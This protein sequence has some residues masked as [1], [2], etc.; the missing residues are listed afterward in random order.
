M[1]NRLEPNARSIAA[2]VVERVARE[3]AFAAAVL[4]AA[5]ERF[6]ELDPRERALATELAYG[7]LRTAPYLEQ[8][9]AKHAAHGSREIE[10]TVRAHLV[11]AGYQLLFLE[12]VPAFAAVSEAVRLVT[13]VRGK[14]VGAFANAVLRRLAA[15]KTGDK[16]AALELAT[17]ASVSP[18]LWTSLVRSLGEA[19]AAAFLAASAPPAVGL[20]IRVGED[21]AAWLERLSAHA[22]RAT[23]APGAV[24]PLA[25]L[26]RGGGDPQKLPFFRD[27]ELAIHEEGAQIV[28]LAL[29]VKAGETVLDACAGRG[30]KTALLAEMVGETG[31]VDAVDQHPSKLTRLAAELLRM[32][33]AVRATYA[34][35]WTV[36]S[37]E[38]PATYDRVL[39]D[40]PCSGTGT[41]RRRPDLAARWEAAKLPEVYDLQVKILLAAAER[42]KSGGTVVYAVCSLLREE[43]EDVVAEALARA[44]WLS[45]APLS[46]ESVALL[47]GL[48]ALRLTPHEHG[49]DGFFLAALRRG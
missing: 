18:Q 8:R 35:D 36:G 15:E 29:G 13:A 20:R 2:H 33:L 40:A 14:R 27:G 17:R 23:F 11:V 45:E 42:A 7:A 9:I 48:T 26:M 22:P 25:I 5:V 31:A 21:R 19:G 43:C 10:T 34:V 4:D 39:V 24:S 37:G 12:R 38:I 41:I 46:G 49:T 28:A 6:P 16:R 30:N 1:Q 3:G 32:R 47:S 44:P